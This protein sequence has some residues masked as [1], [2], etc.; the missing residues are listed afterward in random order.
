MRLCC[1]WTR[2]REEKLTVRWRHPLII[3]SPSFPHTTVYYYSYYYNFIIYYN[4]LTQCSCM[5]FAQF[6][7]RA[8]VPLWQKIREIIIIII[9]ILLLCKRLSGNVHSLGRVRTYCKTEFAAAAA[10]FDN[11]SINLRFTT[12]IFVL[13]TSVRRRF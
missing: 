6:F 13:L 5:H 2:Q 8:R 3:T 9:I 12:I 10:A 7:G 1:S 4:I 11:G